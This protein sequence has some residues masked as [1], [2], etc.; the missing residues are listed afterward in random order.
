M[1]QFITLEQAARLLGMSPEVLKG[2][3]QQREIRAFQDGGS[4]QFRESDVLEYQR[5]IGLGS[6][7]ALSLSDLDLE[8]PRDSDSDI[9]LSDFQLDIAGS[10]EQDVL[11]DDVTV[12]AEIT[13]S[14]SRIIGM[15]PTGKQPSDSDVKLLPHDKGRSA[16]DSDVRLLPA[17]PRNTDLDRTLVA[18]ESGELPAFTV[19]K[20][21]AGKPSKPQAGGIDPGE[22]SLRPSPLLGSS[23]EV[24]LKSSED[25]VSD[26]EL[27]PSSVIDA[28]QPDSGS[29]FELTSLDGSESVEFEAT[30]FAPR[31]SA[32]ADVTGASA[33]NSGINLGRPTDSGI[34]L[35]KGSFDFSSA[36]SIELAPLDGDSGPAIPVSKPAPSRPAAGKVKPQPIDDPG[37][38]SLP[39]RAGSDDP[40]ATSLPVR[41][42]SDPGATSLPVRSKSEK[43]IF[44][45]TDFEVDALDSSRDDRTMQLEAT[46]DFDI[47]EGDSGSE[48][49]ALDEEDVDKNAATA[50]AAAPEFDE[51]EAEAASS[52]QEVVVPHGRSSKKDESAGDW[53]SVGDDD[54]VPAAAAGARGASPMLGAG[55]GPEWG[56]PWVVL[57]GVAS[58]LALF[59]GFVAM[60]LVQNFN[61]FRGDGPASGLVKTIAGLFGG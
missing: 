19:G 34:N 57:L 3:A 10:S 37:A 28:L 58:L 20:A 13:G 31:G 27:T 41:G 39:F 2:K 32:N 56:T 54:A 40:G 4:W 9:D 45:D 18:E 24:E 30:G 26:F 14:S 12:P 33:S 16:S 50:M 21:G 1:A 47:D 35:V 55:S 38:T 51:M 43:D 44:D 8:V 22:T 15:K 5:K 60:D 17:S 59:G 46:S 61:D 53:G 29:D 52:E 23:G 42:S 25:S 11:L 7:P 36:D 48:V 49:F 6:D